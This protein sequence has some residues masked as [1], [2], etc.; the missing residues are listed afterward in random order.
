MAR[1][2]FFVPTVIRNVAELH[3][4]MAQHL[5]RVLRVEKGQVFE[6]SD[7]EQLYLAE[8]EMARK[9]L[10]TFR[11]IEK[12]DARPAP[13]PVTLCVS[14]FKFDHFEWMIEK[15]TELGVGAIQPLV[16]ERSEHGLERAAPKR[17][18]RW[19]RIAMEASQQ[20]RR[21]RVPEVR[22]LA[23][24]G[25][26]LGGEE[27]ARIWLDERPG[28]RPVLEVMERERPAAVTLLLGPE[29]GWAEREATAIAEAGWVN[30]SLGSLVLRAETAAMAALTLVQASGSAYR[31]SRA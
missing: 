16:T 9:E 20:C 21:M 11:V 12:L 4:E 23:S 14:L 8:I 30:T 10:V 1:R 18:E 26:V 31:E 6:I 13:F 29:G 25:K 27:G 5:T 22:E 19:R 24:L 3:G 17:A 7:N 2:L 15:A 28:G